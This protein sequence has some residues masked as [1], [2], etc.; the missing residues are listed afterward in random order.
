MTKILGPAFTLAAYTDTA[1]GLWL[2]SVMAAPIDFVD[3]GLV[4]YVILNLRF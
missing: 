2:R 4:A 1:A 3:P